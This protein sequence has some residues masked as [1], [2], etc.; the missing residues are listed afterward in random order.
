MTSSYY[1]FSVV[2]AKKAVF[3]FLKIK[4]NLK[5]CTQVLSYT[6]AVQTHKYLRDDVIT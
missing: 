1:Y 3:L 2:I 4:K 6:Y 5:F